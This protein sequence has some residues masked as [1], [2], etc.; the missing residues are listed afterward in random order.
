MNVGIWIGLV[1][2]FIGCFVAAC[3]V[4][5]KIFSRSKLTELTEGTAKALRLDAFIE[6]VPR[7]QLVTGATRASLNLVVLV[8]VLYAIGDAHPNLGPWPHYLLAFVIT[9]VLV[10]TFSVAIPLSFARYHPE[11]LLARSMTAL[12]ILDFVGRPLSAVLDR[13]DPIVRRVCGGEKPLSAEDA[14]SEKIM[15]VVEDQEAEGAMDRGQKEM[16]E[17]VFDLTDTT[18]GQIMTPRI[19]MT[20]VEAGARLDQLKATIMREGHS[21]IPVFEKNV[22]HIV[23]ILYAKD[24]LQ[25]VGDDRNGQFD[26]RRTL[27]EALMVPE[28][29]SVKQL[30]TEF[31]SRKVHIAI[32][33]D[34][35]GGTA[36]L[37]TIEDILEE[38][39]G[40]IQDEYEPATEDPAIRR[41]DETTFDIDARVHVDDLNDDLKTRVP[42]DED[43]ETVGGFV[44]STLGHIPNVGERF[45]FENARF[46]VTHAERTRVNR[47]RVEVVSAEEAEEDVG[48]SDNGS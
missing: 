47:V 9:A 18:A 16:I 45:H 44:F 25:L 17:A 39:V 4:A 8:G 32:V 30:L 35:Y 43:Y 37:V 31:K 34:E 46:T 7:L 42:E 1:A 36:G 33:I 48:T 13:L 2:L 26:L 29:K 24:L 38:L 40:E 3:N 14:V 19:E 41:I 20:C 21:R 28:S 22:D 23:G 10:S 5:L 11:K 6:R 12:G 15:T 27:R